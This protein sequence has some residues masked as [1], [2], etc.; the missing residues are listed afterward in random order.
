MTQ[1][2][3]VRG[4]TI[5]L[6]PEKLVYLPKQNSLL[7]A[8][9]HFGKAATFRHAGIPVPAGTSAAML[10]TLT[11]VIKKTLADRLIFLGDFVHSSTRTQADFVDDLIAWRTEHST[12]QL[13][14]VPGNHDLG[15]RKLAAEL[16]MEVQPEPFVEDS[17]SY[18]HFHEAGADVE[19]FSFAG[20]VHP[21]VAI[22]ESAKTSLR[23]PC[24]AIAKDFM[25]LPAFGEFT[26]C[27]VVKHSDFQQVIAVADS[28]LINIA[29]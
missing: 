26:G 29:Q 3:D 25:L 21:A 7:V 24:F 17:F 27:H 8:D 28:R 15:Y 13:V 22:S 23:V 18:C 4:Q 2:I 19:Q 5:Q 9:T 11:R 14:L 20:H 10:T 6:L 16:R 1:R 12:L